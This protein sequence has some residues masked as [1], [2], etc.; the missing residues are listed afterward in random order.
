[1][2]TVSEEHTR[3]VKQK[4]LAKMLD[5][6]PGAVSQAVRRTH[7]CAG[8]PVFDWAKWHPNGKQ[9]EHF[10]VPLQVLKELVPEEEYLKYGI[11]TSDQDE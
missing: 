1:M 7:Y 4:D 6:S 10:E 9:I 2:P 3:K 11:F 8:Y 5:R